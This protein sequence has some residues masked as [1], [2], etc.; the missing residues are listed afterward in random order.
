[1]T[2]TVMITAGGTGGHVFPGLAVAA[3]LVARGWRVFWLGTRDGMEAR[4]CASTASSSRACRSAAFA[5]RAG[6]RCCSARLALLAACWQSRAIIRRRAPDVVL[7]LGGF[8]S[9]PGALAAVALAKPLVLH[10]AN[11]IAGLANRVLA[12]GADRILLGFPERDARPPRGQGR[13]GR[14]SAAR[15]DHRRAGSRGAIRGTHGTAAAARRRRKPRR[16]GAQPHRSG[17]ARADAR[18]RRARASCIR[19]ARS[20]SKRCRRRTRRRASR[21]RAWRSSTTWRRVT[22]RPT[23]CSAAAARSRSPSSPPSASRR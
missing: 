20:T 16:R 10:D 18:R 8:A 15:R 6:R 22:P 12:Y 4:S 7:G 2:G 14:Q 9:F 19:P 13:M 11:A 3:K 23:S 21:Q 17:G 1:M 5:A